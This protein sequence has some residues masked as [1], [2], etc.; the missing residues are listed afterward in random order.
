MASG[1]A[2]S[3]VLSP[4][5]AAAA[6]EVQVSYQYGD[7]S[8][9]MPWFTFHIVLQQNNVKFVKGFTVISD[10]LYWAATCPFPEGGRLVGVSPSTSS[11][12]FISLFLIKI[13]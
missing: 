11:S 7:F 5:T 2:R 12:L 8:H 9:E 4:T 6:R 13:Q 1:I 3:R 10:E